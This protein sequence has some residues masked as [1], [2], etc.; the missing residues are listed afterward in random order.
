MKCG[1]IYLRVWIRKVYKSLKTPEIPEDLISKFILGLYSLMSNSLQV[2]LSD[3]N[4]KQL[5][6]LLVIVQ[7]HSKIIKILELREYSSFED[8]ILILNHF[9]LL[10]SQH[11]PINPPS[12]E[13]TI[14]YSEFILNLCRSIYRAINLRDSLNCQSFIQTKGLK[15]LLSV[16]VS[17]FKKIN[18]AKIMDPYNYYNDIIVSLV[19]LKALNVIIKALNI[20]YQDNPREFMTLNQE[21]RIQ[22]CI[23]LQQISKIGLNLFEYVRSTFNQKEKNE[24]SSPQ[25]PYKLDFSEGLE[26]NTTFHP[27]LVSIFDVL[28]N[29]NANLSTYSEQYISKIFDFSKSYLELLLYLSKE[30]CFITSI[31]QSGLAWRCLE[32][33][34]Y[35]DSLDTPL[36]CNDNNWY[37]INQQTDKASLI[38]RNLLIY[39]NEAFVLKVS[40]AGSKSYILTSKEKSPHLIMELNKID[41]S[42]KFILISF[43]EAMIDLLGKKMIQ[44]IL[45]DFYE[46]IVQ[47]EDKDKNSIH[48]FLK[49]V[50]ANS[51]EPSLFWNEEARC[52]LR[53]ILKTQILSINELGVK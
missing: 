28:R 20:L 51:T 3:M 44:M 21:I 11:S 45:E 24:L 18:I 27:S 7:A 46:P 8:I 37:R 5:G 29:Y 4:E 12:Q 38:L 52:D 25:K 33:V 16:I 49:M 2:P 10:Y 41:K 19:D 9:S 26:N 17:I 14:M 36:K 13:I 6:D 15:A 35:H 1:P 23:N 48:K 42:Q 50:S 32:L 47:P 53:E 43:Y 22:I 31:I 30:S 40:E 34:C 39:S